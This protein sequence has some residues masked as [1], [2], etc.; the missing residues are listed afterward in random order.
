MSSLSCDTVALYA[1]PV[2][3]AAPAEAVASIHTIVVAGLLYTRPTHTVKIMLITPY[4]SN[5]VQRQ[6]CVEILLFQ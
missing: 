3:S 2:A 5:Q 1:W 4:V 6:S